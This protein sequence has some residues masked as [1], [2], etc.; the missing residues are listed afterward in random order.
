MEKSAHI[1]FMVHLCLHFCF[2]SSLPTPKVLARM[3][4]TLCRLMFP[5]RMDTLCIMKLGSTTRYQTSPKEE[6]EGGSL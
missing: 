4:K 6:T 3:N 1:G 2:L 5:S